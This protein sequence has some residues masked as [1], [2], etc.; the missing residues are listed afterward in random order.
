MFDRAM[1]DAS[2]RAGHDAERG[3]TLVL[4]SMAMVGVLVIVALVVDLGWIRGERRSHQSAVDFAALAA[5]E[6]L[7]WDPAPDGVAACNAAVDYLRANVDELPSSLAVPCS[8]LPATCNGLTSPI[9]VTDGGTAG[10]FDVEITY[11]VSDAMISDTT[12]SSPLNLRVNDGNPCERLQ[13][14]MSSTIGSIFGSIAGKDDLDVDA[15][16]VVRQVQA[17]DRRVPSMWLLEPW[18]CAGLVVTGGSH[19]T[20]GNATT[21]GLITLDSDG[22]ACT[23]GQTTVDVGGSTSSIQAIPLGL[24]LPPSISLVAMDRLQTTCNTGNLYACDPADVANGTL[25]PQPEPRANRATRAPVDHKYNCK[26]SYPDYLGVPVEGCTDGL[27][28]HIDNLRAEVGVSGTPAG[29][30][31][32]TDFYGCNNPVVPVTGVNGNWFV[33]CANFRLSSNTVAFNDGNVVFQGAVTLTG[34]SLLFNASNPVANL[35]ATCLATV[36]GCIDQTSADAAWVYMR[37]GDLR[38]SG[39]SSL[40]AIRTMIYQDNGDFEITGGSPPI[41]TSPIEGPFA[42]LSVWT[43]KASSKF[44]ISGGASM[45][46][47]G[48]FFTP[49]ADPM[50]ISGGAPVTPLEAQFISR[51]VEVNGGASIT[52]SPNSVLAVVLPPDPPLLIR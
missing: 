24:P 13:V 9:T 51:R 34:G 15:T 42:G 36:V 30:L 14:H 50:S 11:P 4:A 52:L 22:S 47:E 3:A 5:G 37:N 20:V 12:V 23:G 17:G 35:S 7:G 46:L 8:S 10:D 33:D 32:W 6:A 41:W 2:R 26:T 18:D 40:T 38:L 28:P 1:S 45:Q 48:S 25:W 21:A 16:S 31:K 49:G 43:E 44:K 19:V 29:F 39:G 27:P